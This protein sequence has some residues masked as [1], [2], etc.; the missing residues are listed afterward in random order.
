VVEALLPL[1]FVALVIVG[2]LLAYLSWQ[3]DQKRRAQFASFAAAKGWDYSPHDPHGL[4]GRWNCFPFDRGHS[5][6]ASNVFTGTADGGLPMV[7]FDYL[8]KETTTDSKGHSS[9]TTYRFAVCVVRLPCP[10]PDLFVGNE[11]FLTRIG[12]AIGIEDIEFESDDFNRAFRVKSDNPKFASDLLHPRMME[13]LLARGR[14]IEWRLMGWDMLTWRKGRLAIPDL[15]ERSSLLCRIV[16]GIPSF[17]WKDRGYDPGAQ[18][19]PQGGI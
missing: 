4:E 6:K 15:L 12:S 5:R 2:G 17:V 16:Q 8:Y 7:A 3:A 13:L 1:A 18:T 9:T 11:N 19:Q 10:L 14:G